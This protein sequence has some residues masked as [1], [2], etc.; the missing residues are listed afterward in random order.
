MNLPKLHFMHANSYPAGT[1]GVLFGLLRQHYQVGALDMHGHD[2]DYPVEDGWS[3]L[4]DEAVADLLR[5]YAEPVILVGHSLGGML[6]LMTARRRPDLV[7]CV[8]MLDSPV[9]AGWR[10]KAWR[11]LRALGLA[12]R[13]SPAR[14]SANRRKHWPDPQTAW[15]HFAGKPMFAA[16]PE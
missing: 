3:K 6:A 14:F 5:R 10:A 15:R 7:R 16:W 2:P 4:V 1:Y 11:L 13:L 12:E 8:V 9:V